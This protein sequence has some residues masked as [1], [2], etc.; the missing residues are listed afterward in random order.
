MYYIY[1][2]SYILRYAPILVHN[3]QYMLFNG[4][5]RSVSVGFGRFRGKDVPVKSC[6]FLLMN[7]RPGALYIFISGGCVL[8]TEY[9]G[10]Y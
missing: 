5:F 10:A 6:I 8:I 3:S 4:R 9:S 1:I 7:A 2:H